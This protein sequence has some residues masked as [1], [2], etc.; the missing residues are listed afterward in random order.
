MSLKSISVHPLVQF[1]VSLTASRVN[2]ITSNKNPRGSSRETVESSEND[3]ECMK[4]RGQ[5]PRRQLYLERKRDKGGKVKDIRVRRKGRR[6]EYVEETDESAESG[7]ED[8][9]RERE[10]GNEGLDTEE[11][12]EGKAGLEEVASRGKEVKNL[13]P[14][15]KGAVESEEKAWAVAEQVN[16]RAEA[17]KNVTTTNPVG[18]DT[19]NVKARG[20]VKAADNDNLTRSEQ[21]KTAAAATEDHTPPRKDPARSAPSPAAKPANSPEGDDTLYSSK[22]D[23]EIS[24]EGTVVTPSELCSLSMP[25]AHEKQSQSHGRL[26]SQPPH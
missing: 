12:S 2:S 23:G 16:K 8:G 21:K 22:I 15:V 25:K 9:E 7:T 4:S 3:H 6:K 14:T 20:G 10:N 11:V 24:S 13:Q 26:P 17:D 18:S 19:K 1:E 5:N